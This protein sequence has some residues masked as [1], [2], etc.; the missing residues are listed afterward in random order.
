[1]VK[2]LLFLATFFV[3][4]PL[5]SASPESCPVSYNYHPSFPLNSQQKP[6]GLIAKYFTSLM[7]GGLV[8]AASGAV[9]FAAE[10]KFGP[11]VIPI[12]WFL[13]STLRS[14]IIDAISTDFYCHGIRHNPSLMAGVAQFSDWAAYL[15]LWR[16]EFIPCSVNKVSTTYE[17]MMADKFAHITPHLVHVTK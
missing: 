11:L 2:K 16:N 6:S 3:F 13:F 9:C 12:T 14:T 7:V 4:M 8:G 15:I 1:M 10:S 17:S 5:N